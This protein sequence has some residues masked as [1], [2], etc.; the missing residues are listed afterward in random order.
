M[1]LPH[2]TCATCERDL[3]LTDYNGRQRSCRDCAE[4][5]RLRRAADKPEAK[6]KRVARPPVEFTP[7]LGQRVCDLIAEGE[8]IVDVCAKPGFPSARDIARWRV[9]HDEFAIAL[10]AAK[11]T[12]ADVRA[13][14]IHGYVRE[15]KAGK[16]DPATGKACIDALRWLAGKD[17]P[18]RYGD[19]VVTDLTVRPGRPEEEKPN[20][21][22]WLD[23]VLGAGAVASNVVPLLPAPKDE[24]DAA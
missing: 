9:Q 16:L 23:K 12:R 22:A 24:E 20:T 3:P 5:A 14:T 15:M 8:A 11:D 1:G 21:G 17:S 6:E 7:D 10:A 13:D 4:K 18:A 19:R 2:K